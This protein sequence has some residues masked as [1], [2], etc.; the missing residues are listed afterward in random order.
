M[1]DFPI[2]KPSLAYLGTALFLPKDKVS[3]PP[4]RRALTFPGK[5]E[6]RVLLREHPWHLEV[7]RNYRTTYELEQMGLEVVDMRPKTFENV[8]LRPKPGF[9]FRP[10]QEPAW[11]KMLDAYRDR[12]DLVLRLA[13]GRGKTVMGWRYACEVGGPVMVVSAQEAHL[14][15]WEEELHSLFDLRGSVGWIA[16]KKMEWDRDVVFCTVQTLVKRMESGH[17]PRN[18]GRRFA[19]TI[20]DEVHHMAAAW[21]CKGADAC[22]GRRLGLTATL[23]R[24]DRCEGIV[25]AHLGR[26][27]YDDPEDDTLEPRI[28]IHDT[29]VQIDDS[30][31]NILD[32]TGK[33]NIGK[34]RSHLATFTERTRKVASV[35]R[36]R[37]RQGHTVYALSHSKELSYNLANALE[38]MGIQ[39]G[40]ITGDE[41]DSE[42]RIRQL[43]RHPVI[44]ATVSVGK[45]NYNREEISCVV[46]A[47]PI[48][49]D[50]HAPT[51][52]LQ[53]VGRSLRP[54]EGKL[55]PEV[56]LFDDVGVSQAHGMTMS[57]IKYCRS[58]GWQVRGDE[59]EKRGTRARRAFSR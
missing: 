31:A 4:I 32:R 9:Q 38:D 42:E 16:K 54:L 30:D 6:P 46:I 45:E 11:P 10:H 51:E 44:V 21:F 37:L 43:H 23:T 58:R 53:T 59:W 29:G 28:T 34:M 12:R 15:T 22:G 48:A 52:L 56:D 27:A 13:T 5:E 57:T 55:D 14:R 26:V 50:P 7:P 2:L 49:A 41:K 20:Y 3:L 47:T 40:L 8:D 36:M 33:P 1:A 39:C 24:T 25:T 35:V 18:F 19:L 17:L